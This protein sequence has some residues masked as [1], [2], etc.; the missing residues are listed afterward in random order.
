V[1][2]L[3][4]AAAAV[5]TVLTEGAGRAAPPPA[6]ALTA[7]T[8]VSTDQGREVFLRDCAWC[9]GDQGSGTQFG[10]SLKESGGAAAD[11]YLTTGRMPL[12]DSD[13]EAEPGPPS[14]DPETIQALVQY[15]DELGSG[16]SAPEVAPGNAQ[17]GRELFLDN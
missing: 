4:L 12:E 13:Q 7:S 14:Y 6:T 11:F 1:L 10:P 8:T 15:V 9:H 2:L 16:L 17:S 5:L 3:V